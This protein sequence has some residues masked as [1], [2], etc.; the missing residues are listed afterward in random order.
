[1][2]RTLTGLI[3]FMMAAP[4]FA[5]QPADP[6]KPDDQLTEEEATIRIAEWQNKVNAL[7]SRLDALTND[8][9][10]MRTQL[11][12]LRDDM[13]RCNDEIYALVGATE[14]DVA[15]FREALGRIEGRIRDMKNMSDDQ[16]SQNLAQIDAL[17]N[18]LNKL[19]RNKIAIL[20]EFYDRVL[21]DARDIRDLRT[22]AGR[23][24]STYTVG[25]WSKDRDCLW[26]ISAK[27]QIYGDAFMWPKIWQANTDQIRNPDI[28]HPGQVLTIPP[29]GPKSDE[30]LRAERLYYRKKRAAAAQARRVA[31]ERSEQVDQEEAGSGGK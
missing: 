12:Q 1:M 15:A 2:R 27:D 29:R 23:S 9:S 30:E 6:N 7:Q 11:T 5:Q 26:N 20:P 8:I 14:A 19:R 28:I 3:A 21:T 13:K 31:A 17:E 25:T 10:S 22:R 16:L 24:K 4:L 18:D